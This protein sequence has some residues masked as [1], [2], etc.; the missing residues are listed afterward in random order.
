MRE[1]FDHSSPQTEPYVSD[2]RAW[3]RRKSDA[4]FVTLW[5]SATDWQSVEIY[6]ESL[7]GLS[8]LV[9]DVSKLSVNRDVRLAFPERQMW[10]IVRH[11]QPAVQGKHRV[12]L[13][14][15]CSD[16]RFLSGCEPY[17]TQDNMP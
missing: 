13:E 4:G 12:G 2:R 17:E 11:I 10:A 1:L 9:D 16:R 7:T 3:P 5:T 14:W 8:V 15:G 6:D